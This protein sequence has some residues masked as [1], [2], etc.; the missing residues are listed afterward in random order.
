MAKTIEIPIECPLA[1][2]LRNG[3][4]VAVK[5]GDATYDLRATKR[6]GE[7]KT[8]EPPIRDPDGHLLQ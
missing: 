2:A 8:S 3:E 7:A 5:I 1:Q 4:T 6:G